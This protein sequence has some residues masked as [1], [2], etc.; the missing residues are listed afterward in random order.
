MAKSKI[1]QLVRKELRPHEI[2]NEL[3][4][5][6]TKSVECKVLKTLLTS[7]LQDRAKIVIVPKNTKRK[8]AF[9]PTSLENE[10]VRELRSYLEDKDDKNK[11]TLLMATIPEA[12]ILTYAKRHKLTGKPLA[13]EDDVRKL[14]EQL[15]KQQ[16]QTKPSLRKSFAW[17]N[18]HS[19]RKK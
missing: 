12:M 18:E 14:L 17:L 2:K 5:I 10:L 3:F 19:A 13:P 1:E 7:I 9:I 4:L 8:N 6:D 16:A 11:F 15:Q